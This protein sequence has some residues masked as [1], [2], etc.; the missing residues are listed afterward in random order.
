MAYK[1]P[2]GFKEFI[3]VILL[4]VVTVDI[5][6]HRGGVRFNV[7]PVSLHLF[8]MFTRHYANINPVHKLIK[9]MHEERDNRSSVPNVVRDYTKIKLY[10][11]I[12]NL[13]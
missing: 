7:N 13:N 11:I 2:F 9:N 4:V 10:Q 5:L 1:L 6:Q 8:P 12:S 3:S